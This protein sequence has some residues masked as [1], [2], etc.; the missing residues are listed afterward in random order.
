MI[1]NI[2]KIDDLIEISEMISNEYGSRFD[3]SLLEIRIN[4]DEDTVKRVNDDLYYRYNTDGKP[5]EADDVI[6]RSNGIIFKYTN[7]E[8]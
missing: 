3:T 8:K 7:N 4:V 6:V 2:P 5:E 1:P